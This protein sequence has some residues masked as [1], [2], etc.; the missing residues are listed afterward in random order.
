MLSISPEFQ[1]IYDQGMKDEK[2]V[3]DFF[4]A[5]GAIVTPAS[6]EENKYQDI[7]CY[8][9]GVPVSI[10]AQ[11]KGVIFHNIGLELANELTIH[12]GHP[13]TKQYLVNNSM[14]L[15]QIQDL[16]NKGIWEPGWFVNSKAKVYLVY[17]GDIIRH[18]RKAHIV[19]TIKTKGFRRIRCLREDTLESKGGTY[20]YYNTVNGYLNWEDLLCKSYKVNPTE[21]A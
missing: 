18:Y 5:N 16:I 2:F 13:L 15:P 6:T 4:T 14:T 10:K 7:D 3:M 19:Q 21:A 8:I 1:R 12:Q 11:H 9:N 20:R 17:Q